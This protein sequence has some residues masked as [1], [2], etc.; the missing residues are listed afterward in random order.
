[1][2]L[3][4]PL[5]GAPVSPLSQE[6][7]QKHSVRSMPIREDDEIQVVR[8]HWQGQQGGAAAQKETCH[9]H[10]A[11]AAGAGCGTPVHGGVHP[12]KVVITRLP[13]DK[14]RENILERKAQSRQVGKEKGKCKEELIEK[15]QE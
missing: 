15:M 2:P 4:H 8:G 13:L 10:G 7:R 3:P 1:M 5:A 6:L 14:D 12:G 11:G 9:L